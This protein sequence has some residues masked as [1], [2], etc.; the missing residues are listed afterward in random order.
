VLF[1]FK[2][3][4]RGQPRGTYRLLFNAIHRA[5]VRKPPVT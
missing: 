1:G 4:F 3:Q 2:P 5:T